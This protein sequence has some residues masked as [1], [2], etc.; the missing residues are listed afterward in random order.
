MLKKELISEELELFLASTPDFAF[1]KRIEKLPSGEVKSVYCGVSPAFA[2]LVG[3]KSVGELEGLTDFEIFKDK[4]LAERYIADDR[5]VL[6]SG[7]ALP[8]FIEPIPTNDERQHWASTV[9][10]PIRSG[11]GEVIGI[12]GIGRDIT[13]AVDAG[14]NGFPDAAK[15]I[16]AAETDAMTGFLNHNA[17]IAHIKSFIEHESGVHSL[18]MIDVDNFKS[19]NDNMGHQ[20]GDAVI[21][22]I[23]EA[24]RAVFRQNDIVGRVGG[25]EFLVLMKN[26]GDEHITR[27]K[28]RE[29]NSALQFKVSAASK[30]INLSASI[31]ISMTK[32]DGKNFDRLYREADTALYR[33]KDR[34][35]NCFC[36]LSDENSDVLTEDNEAESVGIMQLHLLLDNMDAGVVVAEVGKEIRPIYVSRSFFTNMNR[37]KQDTGEDGEKLLSLIHPEDF[38]AVEAATRSAAAGEISEAVYR[39]KFPEGEGKTGTVYNWRH[40]R[41]AKIPSKKSERRVI[42]VITDVTKMKTAEEQLRLAEERYRIAMKQTGGL[43][44][45]VDI[46][47]RTLYQPEEVTRIYGAE[48]SVFENAPESVLKL[49]VIA[50]ESFDEF[51]RMYSDIYSHKESDNYLLL[52]S[53][54]NGGF[55]HVKSR[56]E[57]LRNSEGKPVRAIG[58]TSVMNNVEPELRAF[59]DEKRLMKALSEN[60]LGLIVVNLTRGSVDEFITKN[61]SLSFKSYSELC[62]KLA[63]LVVNDEDLIKMRIMLKAENLLAS[64]RIGQS[65]QFAA[66]SR[67]T[68]KGDVHKTNLSVNL[69]RHPLTGD[70]YAFG[71]YSDVDSVYRLEKSVGERNVKHDTTTHLYTPETMRRLYEELAKEPAEGQVCTF[72]MLELGGLEEVKRDLGLPAARKLLAEFGRICRVLINGS[73]I[74]G[75]LD[76]THALIIRADSENAEKHK[77]FCERSIRQTL[78][79]YKKTNPELEIDIMAGFTLAGGEKR[80]YEELQ[81]EAAVAC[82][83]SRKLP[84]HPVCEYTPSCAVTMQDASDDDYVVRPKVLV[85]DDDRITRIQLRHALESNYEVLEA[86]NGVSAL[87]IIGAGGISLVITD[88]LMPE[89]DGWTLIDRMKRDE[90]TQKLPVI[91]ITADERSETEIKALGIGASDVVVKPF[92]ASTLLSRV[93]SILTR[94]RADSIFEQNRLYQLRLEQQEKLLQ[95]AEYDSVTGLYNRQAFYRHV[96]E[97]LDSDTESKYVIMRWDLDNFKVLNDF[98]G[99]SAGDKALRDIAA[100]ARD[101]FPIGSVLARLDSDHFV[102]LAALDAAAVIGLYEDMCAWAESYPV[103]FR[104]SFRVGVYV[105][106]DAGIDV[107][108]MCDRALLALRSIKGSYATHLKYYDESLRQRLLSEQQLLSEMNYALSSGQFVLYFQP[109]YDTSG[110]RAAL[111]GAEALVRWQHPTEGLL[112]PGRFIPLFEKNGFIMTLDRYVWE[113]ACMYLRSWLDE[114]LSPLPVSVNISRL[115]LYNP[116][117]V[118]IFRSL[119][120]K[121][122]IAPSMLH[123]EITETAF[124][125]DSALLIDVVKQLQQSG[126]IVEMDDFGSGYSSL[127]TLK[128]VPV[129]VLKLDLRFL[130]QTENSSR[131]G[132]II[133]SVLKMAHWL[134]MPVI[135]EGVETARQADYLKTVGCTHAQGYLFAKPMPDSDYKALMTSSLRG[136]GFGVNVKEKELAEMDFWNPE[137]QTTLIFNSFVG[138]AGIFEYG[139]GQLTGLRFNDK[140]FVELGVSRRWLRTIC[141]DLLPLIAKEDKAIFIA[142]I[143][144]AVSTGTEISSVTRWSFGVRSAQEYFLKIRIRRIAGFNG[145]YILFLAVENVTEQRG[146]KTK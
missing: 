17:V 29:L 134:K 15:L 82:S 89:M 132:I 126:F 20:Q 16:L 4:E 116:R 92:V 112:P 1:I 135:A 107:G 7:K 54:E 25:D 142:N 117:L 32:G 94:R 47:N 46:E 70:V 8:S 21:I 3:R 42:A 98:H 27:R 19:V 62:D 31:G 106:D 144:S 73:A 85:V 66:C 51:R 68:L 145:K 138:A 12:W 30:E 49:G 123:L 113:K 146:A 140:F 109:Q 5:R 76:E 81:R 28:A 127:N 103:D 102:A 18:F 14:R 130:V 131:G 75:M 58:V 57:F 13:E 79:V 100:R 87:S 139:M 86:E 122:G 65:W 129:D 84:S 105:I 22:S 24:I 2:A 118:P 64:F 124:M 55:M 91:V 96:R 71:F 45:E 36:L 88:I 60:L 59:E 52:T 114:G 108:L 72:T 133:N 40:L 44:W 137:A 48:G 39:V 110:E 23:A 78:A 6:E 83:L 128:D 111:T 9:K 95:I 99:V 61:G 35:K 141:D 77:M 67:I 33:S 37:S 121:Y 63:E 90:K 104:F 41:V 69:L 38:P 11:S 143:E 115:N 97:K 101:A 26:S 120:E 10:F 50:K 80:G 74:T 119:T 34:G 53:G 125:D 93:Q 43:I 136:E 56:Y